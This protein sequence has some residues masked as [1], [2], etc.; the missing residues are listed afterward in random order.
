[1]SHKN[2]I[3]CETSDKALFS[4]KQYEKK[5]RLAR[6][7]VEC[8]EL[9]LVP[10]SPTIFD[11]FNLS[12]A[13]VNGWT[14]D[15]V[16]SRTPEGQLLKDGG[17]LTWSRECEGSDQTLT[18]WPTNGNISSRLQHPDAEKPTE[19]YRQADRNQVA[20]LLHKLFQNPREHTDIGYYFSVDNNFNGRSWDQDNFPAAGGG[21]G[22]GARNGG[23]SLTEKVGRAKRNR[24]Q[25]RDLS[26]FVDNKIDE[27]CN[28]YKEGR[29]YYGKYCRR[30][31][32]GPQV[33]PIPREQLDEVCENWRKGGCRMEFCFRK[34][35]EE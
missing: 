35:S 18:F 19:L 13:S 25:L 17:A 31:H 23:G 22:N 29:C 5:V 34:H 27:E 2:C 21:R 6:C 9:P 28:N 15:G 24:G 16:R 10:L 30:Q 1:M 12:V 33:D 3:V 4:K 26:Y 8:M 14:Y 11:A 7:C 20:D 32:G